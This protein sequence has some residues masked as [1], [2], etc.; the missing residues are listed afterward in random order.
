MNPSWR[1][2]ATP[3]SSPISSV[4]KRF[5]TFS[6]E[7]GGAPEVQVRECV[8]ELPCERTDRRAAAQRRVQRV[9]EPDVRGGRTQAPGQPA[10]TIPA[11]PRQ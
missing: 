10:P 4:M 5:S 6:D 3:S 7:I 1:S 11:I 9:L 2:A 8:A